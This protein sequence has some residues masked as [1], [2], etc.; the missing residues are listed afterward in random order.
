MNSCYSFG[1]LKQIVVYARI[2]KY[3]HAPID[4]D[5]RRQLCLPVCVC[6]KSPL[7]GGM[8]VCTHA[9]LLLGSEVI[10]ALMRDNVSLNPKP[11]NP[12]PETLNPK[13]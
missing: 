1:V 7:Y 4:I 8:H 11:P 2:H 6:W 13:P 3:M 10:C 9:C 12:K 5:Y